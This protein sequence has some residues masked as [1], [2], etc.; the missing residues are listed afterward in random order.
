M[1]LML[2]NIMAS[3][4]R[5]RTFHVP[6]SHLSLWYNAAPTFLIL[7]DFLVVGRSGIQQHRYD[8]RLCSLVQNR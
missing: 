4:W 2:H 8:S 6:V 3:K 1:S 7:L 5:L